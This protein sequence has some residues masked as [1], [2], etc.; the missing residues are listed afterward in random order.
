M[1]GLLRDLC[2]RV[3]RFQAANEIVS[4]VYAAATPFEYRATLQLD[5]ASA[6]RTLR[7]PG[8]E[9]FVIC[10]QTPESGLPVD[11]K[12]DA[13]TG[14]KAQ[15]VGGAASQGDARSLSERLQAGKKVTLA[16]S[17]AKSSAHSF[18]PTQQFWPESLTV[19][20]IGDELHL[21]WTPFKKKYSGEDH[22]RVAR[23][24]V[25]SAFA[26]PRCP[27]SADATAG[28]LRAALAAALPQQLAYALTSLSPP[29]DADVTATIRQLVGA[30][31][32]DVASVDDAIDSHDWGA[33]LLLNQLVLRQESGVQQG[34][35]LVDDVLPMILRSL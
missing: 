4:E 31:S 35:L 17:A 14:M 21:L 3:L 6:Q 2:D 1:L 29:S 9:R 26:R 8:A 32:G 34:S 28:A 7:I 25:V 5:E 22:H 33:L 10:C 16:T 27:A 23:S 30:A 19:K 15:P 11:G 18:V 24:V 20:D 12:L 13:S